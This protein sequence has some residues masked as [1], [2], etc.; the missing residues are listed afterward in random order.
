VHRARDFPQYIPGAFKTSSY[1]APASRHPQATLRA[2]A[3]QNVR[4]IITAAH[5]IFNRDLNIGMEEIAAEAGVGIATLYRRFP[6]KESLMR[7]VLEQVYTDRMEPAIRK[8][9]RQRDPLKGVLIILETAL[10]TA[11]SEQ[12]VKFTIPYS[13]ALPL[14][15]AKWLFDPLS[16]L[17]ERGQKAGVFRSDLDPQRDAPR[18]VL[19]LVNVVPTFVPGSKGWQRYLHLVMDALTLQSGA[20]LYPSEPLENPF[21]S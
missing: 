11:T 2:D 8:G 7:A 17:L 16:E 10:K 4:R 18:I 1:N 20:E 21:L 9:L 5:K 14:D 12:G 13:W 15:M 19:M 6:T 3:A